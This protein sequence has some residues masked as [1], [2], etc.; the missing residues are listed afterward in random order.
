LF[1]DNTED[2]LNGYIPTL[3]QAVI[4]GLPNA[5]GIDTKK[6]RNTEE[7]WARTS[8]NGYEVSS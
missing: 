3:T 6:N 1:G 8:Q 2:R 4:R 5:I 7:G